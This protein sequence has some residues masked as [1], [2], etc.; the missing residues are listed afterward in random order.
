MCNLCP[1]ELQPFVFSL[2]TIKPFGSIWPLSLVSL[3]DQ[4]T[5]HLSSTCEPPQH[6][7]G[8]VLIPVFVLC[9]ASR[10]WGPPLA[11]SGQGHLCT[12]TEPFL[13]LSKSEQPPVGREEYCRKAHWYAILWRKKDWGLRLKIQVQKEKASPV[14]CRAHLDW[15]ISTMPQ[16]GG[17]TNS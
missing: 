11:V 5:L 4:K 12:S 3:L 14:F 16:P 1:C 8:S 17:R 10:F 13:N 7:N 15:K 9:R 6:A 2:N